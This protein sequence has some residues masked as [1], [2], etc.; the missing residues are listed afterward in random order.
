MTCRDCTHFGGVRMCG[1]I[2]RCCKMT[3]DLLTEDSIVCSAFEPSPETKKT[4]GR[5]VQ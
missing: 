5:D 2:Y 1:N 3:G 4:V